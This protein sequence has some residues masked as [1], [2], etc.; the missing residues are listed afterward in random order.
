MATL[1]T[2]KDFCETQIKI[3]SEN[4]LKRTYP[5]QPSLSLLEIRWQCCLSIPGYGNGGLTGIKPHHLLL[6]SEDHCDQ[7]YPLKDCSGSSLLD[8]LI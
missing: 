8:Y 3:W 1:S 7:T 6:Q 2:S 5:L 4:F